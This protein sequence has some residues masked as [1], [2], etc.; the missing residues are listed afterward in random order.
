MREWL[1]RLRALYEGL[2]RREQALVAGAGGTLL[3]VLVV[4]GGVQPILAA[5]QGGRDRV[6]AAE[7]D[8]RLAQQWRARLDQVNQRLR[9]V[10][11]R[12][13]AGP[14]RNLRTALDRLRN[15]AG[16]SKFDSIDERPG[17]T[18]QGYRETQIEV[19]LRAVTLAQVVKYLH[20]VESAQDV[21]SVKRLRIARRPD[22]PELLDVRFTVSSFE[23]A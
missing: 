18:S 8:L 21:L 5:V 11:R 16:I 3:L 15:Q 17:R 1:D 4:F 6:E 19:S 12:I 7:Q 20:A 2:N 23:P 22:D 9:A 10:E 13:E 14:Q